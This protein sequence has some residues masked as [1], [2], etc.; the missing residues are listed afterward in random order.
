M[1]YHL[2]AKPAR[3]PR[4][5]PAFTMVDLTVLL[6]LGVVLVAI[7]WPALT[8]NSRG[9][10]RQLPNNTQV[11]GIHQSMVMYAQ[12]NK[13]YFPGL[14]SAGADGRTDVAARF[15]IL[16]HGNYFTGEYA[17]SPSETFTAWTTGPV[18]PHH[19]SYAMSQLPPT[20][21]RRAEWSETLNTEAAVLGDRNK[22]TAALPHSV[23]T[24]A[25]SYPNW[26]GTVAYNDNHVVFESTHVVETAFG[27]G[28]HTVT[29][30]AD[31]LFAEDTTSDDDALFIHTSNGKPTP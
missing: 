14:D 18:Y 23:H 13:G 17:V 4:P 27:T 1:R 26:R 8:S 2:R 3:R 21:Q 9:P 6:V 16:L 31:H 19:Y 22:G 28:K 20:G 7:L 25:A 5:L 24:E 30:K 29:N 12:G 11:R 15:E 10:R